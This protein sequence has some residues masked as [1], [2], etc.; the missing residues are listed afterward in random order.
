V[1]VRVARP[2]PGRRDRGRP[3]DH[4]FSFWWIWISLG[5][6][7]AAIAEMGAVGAPYYRK[8]K[9]PSCCGFRRAAQER[10]GTRCAAELIASDGERDLRVVVLV[11]IL[12]LMIWKPLWMV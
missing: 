10:R 11:I 9:R 6:L 8:V 7:V 3:A 4:Y 5:L 1:D 12:W 2:P